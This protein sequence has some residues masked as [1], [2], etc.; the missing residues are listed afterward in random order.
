MSG[1]Q[2]LT[3]MVPNEDRLL[4]FGSILGN[5]TLRRLLRGGR[6]CRISIE[7]L[8]NAHL[9]CRSVRGARR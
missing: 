2:P 9:V 8:A 1:R 5:A 4:A 6:R 7:L 3:E